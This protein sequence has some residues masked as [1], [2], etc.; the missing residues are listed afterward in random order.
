MDPLAKFVELEKRKRDLEDELEHVKQ[1]ASYVSEQL[2]EEWAMR[3]QQ[4]ANVD[5]FTVY[6]ARDFVCGKRPEIETSQVCA[7]LEQV[8]LGNLVAPAYNAQSLKAWIKSKLD[9]GDELPHEI[10]FAVNYQTINRLK[11]RKA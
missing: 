10:D 5:G 6:I 8:G 3:G 7:M 4:N 2:L 9:A 1:E 11:A